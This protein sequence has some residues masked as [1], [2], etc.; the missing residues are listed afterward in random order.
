VQEANH[1]AKK[2]AQGQRPL[3]S[4]VTRGHA[5]ASG[6]EAG[7]PGSD[8]TMSV[9]QVTTCLFPPLLT[10]GTPSDPSGRWR[11]LLGARRAGKTAYLWEATRLWARAKPNET[12]AGIGRAPVKDDNVQRLLY[13]VTCGH[14]LQVETLARV[15]FRRVRLL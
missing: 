1:G 14:P 6:V 10:C 15:A 5:A 3:V 7:I 8:I 12:Q 2:K 9:D 13:I 4:L 11:H